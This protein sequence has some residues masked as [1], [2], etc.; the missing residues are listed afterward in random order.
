[1]KQFY[2][3]KSDIMIK[4][5]ENVKKET[6]EAYKLQKLGFK[7]GVETGWARAKQLTTEK[8]ISIQDLRYM[9]NWYARHIYASY[10]TF[11]KWKESGRPLTPEWYNKRGI[12]SLYIWGGD[13][14]LKWVNSQKNID[15]LNK[16]FNKNYKK[17]K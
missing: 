16:Y 9:R 15:L 2:G 11:K 8:S 17:I 1:M 12:I 7:G 13:S 4:I 14:G 5:P 3:K 6:F 10:P